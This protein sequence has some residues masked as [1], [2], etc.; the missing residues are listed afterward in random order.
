MSLIGIYKTCMGNDRLV[1][2]FKLTILDSFQMLTLTRIKLAS[3]E[4]PL[5]M[6]AKVT[7]EA[8]YH[9]VPSGL[10]VGL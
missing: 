1:T 6:T 8:E 4:P 5:Q 3:V 7:N 10:L 2:S 9:L